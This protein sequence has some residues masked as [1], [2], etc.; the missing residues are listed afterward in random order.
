[1]MG[2]GGGSFNIPKPNV[3]PPLLHLK[4]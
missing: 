1:M 2:G 3:T 4:A